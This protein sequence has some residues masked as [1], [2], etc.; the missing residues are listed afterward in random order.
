MP[1]TLQMLVLQV[2]TCLPL[3]TAANPIDDYVSAPEPHFA[4]S[5]TGARVR[6]VGGTAHILNVTSLQWMT[7]ANASGPNGALWTHQ[8]AIVVPAGGVRRSMALSV[9]TAG[10]NEGPPK[11]PA[12]DEEYLLL[13]AVLANR[14]GAIG[15]VIYQIPNCPITYPSDPSG[16]KRSEDSMIAWAWHEFLTT[17]VHDPVWLPRFPMV[18]AG[19]QCMRAVEE[20]TAQ[21]KLAAIE[22]WLVGGASKRG[23]T[24]WMVGATQCATCVQIRG[25]FPLV[26]IVPNL[27]QSVH[28]Q[29]QSLGGFTFAFRD[30]LDADIIRYMDGPA[31]GQLLSNVDPV[32]PR[33][34]ARLAQLPKL[35]IVSS[36]DE[37]MQ[38]DW[39]ALNDSWAGLPGETHLLIAPNSEHTLATGIPEVLETVIAFYASIA[40]G[41]EASARPSFDVAREA[42]TGRITVTVPAG[43]PPPAKVYLRTDETASKRRD[44]RWVRMANNETGECSILHKEVPIA[45]MEGGGNCVVPRFWKKTALV[46]TSPGNGELVFAATPPTPSRKGHFVG[47][48]IE[49]LFDSSHAPRAQFMLS[50]P[51]YVWPDTLPFP[52]CDLAS[53]PTNLL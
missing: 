53:C 39:T 17:P 38:F 41:E 12:A 28:L 25:L 9:M 49:M 11:P 43:A 46:P 40:A 47:Y 14:T 42:T 10:C 29:R 6:T 33:Y 32:S 27:L 18:K 22:G 21:A 34:A 31:F 4:W 2:I 36:N 13:A 1:R 30:Y 26:P 3:L 15:V 50:T 52:D 20:Y 19:F 7:E 23:W 37:F 51:G 8:V 16:K 45:P 5:D 24:S 48:Y 44:F 35:A